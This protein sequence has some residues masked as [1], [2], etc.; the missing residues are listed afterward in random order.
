[1]M[2]SAN[3][4]L[5][6]KE[7]FPNFYKL[8]THG[9]SFDNNYSPRNS[10]A[11]GNNEFSTI[12]SL[13][14]IANTC[15][16]NTYINNTY[17]ESMFAKFRKAGYTVETF[18]DFTEGYYKRSIAHIN[19]GAEKYYGVQS[20]G[21]PFEVKYGEWASDEDLM[22][23]YLTIIDEYDKEKPFFSYITT[24]SSHMPYSASSAYGDIYLDLTKDTFIYSWII[25]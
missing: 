9:Y 18:H 24:V 6:N 3:D 4:I 25:I 23:K 8:Y 2:E 15:T 11:T 21:I 1:M 19:F 10:C 16:M 12:T 7:Y 20:L 14:S 13:Y 5:I 22:N 17:E